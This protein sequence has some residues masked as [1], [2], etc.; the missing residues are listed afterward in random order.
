[1]WTAPDIGLLVNSVRWDAC[2]KAFSIEHGEDAMSIRAVWTRSTILVAA[3]LMVLSLQNARA[4]QP[5]NPDDVIKGR[6]RSKI[7]Y[8]TISGKTSSGKTVEP[9][10]GTGFFISPKGFALTAA[11]LFYRDKNIADPDGLWRGD[12]FEGRIGSFSDGAKNFQL[13]ERMR[14]QFRAEAFN[15]SNTP[16]YGKANT[17]FGAPTFG[18]V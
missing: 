3:G 1:M 5:F 12:F 8:L 9:I 13:I 2:L 10:S 4:E 14:L 6:G 15:I 7:V 17:T 11:H 16:Q 18:V